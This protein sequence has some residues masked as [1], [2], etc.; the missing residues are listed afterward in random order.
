MKTRVARLF[1]LAVLGIFSLGLVAQ[2]DT[3]ELKDGQR[4]HGK[5]LGGSQ[6][7]IQFEVNGEFE[8]FKTAEV[9]RISFV[10]EAASTSESRSVTNAGSTRT[11]TV[12]A[13]TQLLVRMIDSVDSSQNRV[14]DI[15]HAS[16]EENLVVGNV[17]VAPKG[18]DVYGRLAEAKSAGHISG[19]SELALELTGISIGGNVHPIVTRH[20]EAEGKS[21]GKQSAE[22]IG[23]GAALGAIIGAI[24]GGGKGA[25][26]GA[27]AGAGAGTVIQVITHGEQVRV[28]SESVLEFRVE[29]PFT[30]GLSQS[31]GQ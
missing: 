28:P 3:L 23:G 14:G 5:F 22:R 15:F 4:I 2:A 26:I 17:M 19:R 16:L 29:Q 18:A 30:V 20:Y 12:P 6:N 31:I 25:A 10:D 13:G 27:G 7:E 24:A 8:V 11:V 21:R 1:F 9:I